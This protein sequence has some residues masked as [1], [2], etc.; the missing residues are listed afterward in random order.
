MGVESTNSFSC[1]LPS[2]QTCV[3]VYE[4]DTSKILGST[5][6][7]VSVEQLKRECAQHQ[8]EKQ[9]LEILVDELQEE[10]VQR[11]EEHHRMCAQARLVGHIA[12]SYMSPAS[13]RSVGIQDL[14]G[15][16]EPKSPGRKSVYGSERCEDISDSKSLN[17]L[18]DRRALAVERKKVQADKRLLREERA[19][20]QAMLDRLTTQ[21]RREPARCAACSSHANV[22]RSQSFSISNPST[23]MSDGHPPDGP[24]RAS[25][26][27]AAGEDMA[28]PAAVDARREHGTGTVWDESLVAIK[29]NKGDSADTAGGRAHF[30]GD[31][32][33]DFDSHMDGSRP[34]KKSYNSHEPHSVAAMV[35]VFEAAARGLDLSQLAVKESVLHFQSQTDESR[36]LRCNSLQPCLQAQQPTHGAPSYEASM[37][38]DSIQTV[39]ILSR[40][41]AVDSYDGQVNLRP[42]NGY[43]RSHRENRTVRPRYRVFGVAP[44]N[45][46]MFAIGYVMCLSKTT[47]RPKD[48]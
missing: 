33:T 28:L 46:A 7:E 10:L 19:R 43:S 9:E 2:V 20:L 23:F 44:W 32:C 38:N 6:K 36:V 1:T 18:V 5:V 8:A 24:A 21:Q 41:T 25:S 35:T 42:T 34:G 37:D 3:D 47:R 13:R 31:S 15:L 14:L 27:P 40:S 29:N 17:L 45:V 22:R 12:A 11:R 48:M 30:C 4:E 26:V 39:S 16:L